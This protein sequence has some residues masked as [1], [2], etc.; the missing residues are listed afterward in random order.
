MG[1]IELV[2]SAWKKSK[3]PTA[4]LTPEERDANACLHP[5][6]EE[7][8]KK[9][10]KLIEEESTLEP[11]HFELMEDPDNN[12][13]L[14]YGLYKIDLYRAV[15]KKSGCWSCSRAVVT[16]LSETAK[17]VGDRSTIAVIDKNYGWLG[18][19]WFEKN[20]NTYLLF[21]EDYHGGYGILDL[22][23]GKKSVYKPS[24]GGFCW[25]SMSVSESSGHAAVV[26]CFWAAPYEIRLYRIPEDPMQVPWELASLTREAANLFEGS[27]LPL[28]TQ[29]IY[30]TND[31]C[32]KGEWG[33]T[34][35]VDMCLDLCDIDQKF[36]DLLEDEM[37]NVTVR[38]VPSDE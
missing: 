24:L 7:S 5:S 35:H 6:Y 3:D 29:K 16:G 23:T 1:V 10:K 17:S 8:R 27:T 11:L 28:R 2:E 14:E 19:D 32:E 15:P 31:P 20:G 22:K 38:K 26:G 33:D 9:L 12:L 18:H 21:S 13:R 37:E 34:L 4:E 30:W 25:S 36:D